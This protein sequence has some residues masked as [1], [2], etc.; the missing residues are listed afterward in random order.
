MDRS[1]V[2]RAAFAGQA[3]AFEDA[4][5][6]FG[7]DEV[8]E[9]L[10]RNTPVKGS[11]VVLEVA[12]G[13]GIY[14]RAIAGS[15][16]AVV[17]VDLT[18][19]MLN[20]GKRAADASGIRNMVWQVGDATKLP[21]LPETFDLVISR[22]AI[23]H[24]ENPCVPIDEMVRVTRSGGTIVVVDM[25]VLD[26]HNQVRFNNL[27]KRRDPSHTRALTRAQLRESIE[28]AG[29]SITHSATRVNV[30]NAQRWL[31][32]TATPSKEAAVIRAAW[33]DELAGGPATGMTPTMGPDGI[34]FVHHWDL[35]VA[36]VRSKGS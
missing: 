19:E 32:Q 7:A 26:E 12:A 1:E 20:E 23:H 24:F 4:A 36:S 9:W 33:T 13:T 31:D 35:V 15:V 22:L 30:L 25:V 11:D 17:A 8:L 14:G 2:V 10:T 5:R 34:E 21:F 3:S 28:S 16:S 27:E 18:P 29:C 6:H